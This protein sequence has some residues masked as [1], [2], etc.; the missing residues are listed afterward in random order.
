MSNLPVIDMIIIAVYIGAII[1]IGS[2]FGLKNGDS[3]HFVKAG[4]KLP[5]WAVGLS[6]FGTYL[7]SNTFIGVTGKAFGE[8]WNSFVFSLSLPIA[9]WIASKYFVPFY[10]KSGHISAYEHM[11]QRFG[12]W[13]R[14]Y[15]DIGYLLTQLAR[16]GSIMFGVGIVIQA[17]INIPLAYIIII[18]GV[19]VTLYTLLGGIQAV[20]WTDVV[21]SI[22]LTAGAFLVLILLTIDV[23]G[24]MI[25]IIEYGMDYN[26]FSLGKMSFSFNHSTFW[27]VMLY[28]LFINLNNFGIDQNFIQRYHAADS[29]KSARN[30]VWLAAKLYLPVSM[31]FFFIGTGLW[32]YYDQNPELIDPLRERVRIETKVDQSLETT[33]QST[34]LD[35]DIA[36][37]V[38][39]EYMIQRLPVGLTGLL[40]A[41]LFAAAMSSIDSSLNSS[42]TILWADFFKKY[43]RKKPTEK[44][45]ILVLRINTLVWGLLGTL[46]GVAL[47]GTKSILDTW[48]QL[49]G[50][51]AGG[52]LGLFLLG[53]IVR[54]A[55]HA[56]ALTSVFI[57]L[58][59]II[60]MNFPG[61][62][63]DNLSYLKNPFH[64]NM[65]VVI[66]TLTI[67]LTGLLIT[68]FL[69]YKKGKNED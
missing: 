62:I 25:G 33:N 20:I 30:S 17:F 19:L 59:V 38:F 69:N 29:M 8:D 44:S 68:G 15:M 12:S 54:K 22:I 23:P 3:D 41:A 21:Q 37:R 14:I 66:G 27:V 1:V 43:I 45:S 7:S 26:K 52:M 11:E 39:P 57:G 64:T 9:A 55:T 65:I 2:Y 31:V 46:V 10:R 63:P 47:I 49:S 5:G 58:L 48:W 50:I 28:G 4:G 35:T 56:I 67:F 13:A 51:F 32:V 40:I 42:A 24:G 6:I 18:M 36:D 34:I 60:W 16:M 53:I 61:I